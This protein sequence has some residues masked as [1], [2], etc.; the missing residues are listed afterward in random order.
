MAG[1]CYSWIAQLSWEKS[2]WTAPLD[3]R[4]LHPHG[5]AVRVPAEQVTAPVARL[6]ADGQVP[7]C[8]FDAGYDPIALSCD[9]AQIPVAVLVRLRADRV[10]YAD[11]A[12]PAAGA[13]GRP[14][15]HG[16][17][18]AGAEAASW[19]APAAQLTVTDDQYGRVE[20]RAWSGVHPQAGR[21][22][23]VGGVRGAADRVRHRVAG[24]GG[25]SWL[26]WTGPGTVDLDAC[27][28]A[29]VH[30]FDLEHT[31]RFAKSTLGWTTP[32]LRHPEQ[33]DRWT[34][35]IVAGYTQLRLACPIVTDQRLPWERR[36]DLGMRSPLRV[37]R[38]FRC[39]LLLGTPAS[40][41]KP[42]SRGPGRP[43]GS[44]NHP[45]P[46]HPA[47]KKTA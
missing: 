9:L 25:A 18:F 32:A 15:R 31:L 37:R 46:R 42:C 30:R 29:Y 33:A 45:T 21:S 28:R 16:F 44:R 3:V 5:D 13:C 26:W 41:P 43:A 2:S 1:W 14:H 40:P 20:L 36:R 39:L 6:G 7:L 4:R 19:S 11:P 17:W 24:A 10:F 22:R 23:P 12:P 34:W 8:V 35:L 27:W 47:I 38:G